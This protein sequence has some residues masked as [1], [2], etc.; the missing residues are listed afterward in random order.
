MKPP[1]WI[2]K[3]R[4]DKCKYR[5]QYSFYYLCLA[6][7]EHLVKPIATKPVLDEHLHYIIAAMQSVIGCPSSMVTKPLQIL[8]GLILILGASSRP[9][10]YGTHSHR[11]I[12]QH[13]QL[14]S[15]RGNVRIQNIHEAIL[16]GRTSSSPVVGWCSERSLHI[17]IGDP[18]ICDLSIAEPVDRAFTLFPFSYQLAWGT[19]VCHVKRI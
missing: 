14:T 12:M 2:N 7:P 13:D 9:Q 10:R 11:S 6:P 17:S 3:S 18:V 16:S 19:T 8:F 5:C 1:S 15:R 4:Q